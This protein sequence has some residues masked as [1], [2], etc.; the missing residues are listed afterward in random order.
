[1][2]EQPA[3][4]GMIL[5]CLSHANHTN[6]ICKGLSDGPLCSTQMKLVLVAAEKT[7]MALSLASRLSADFA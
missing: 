3:P 5:H 7:T 4:T 2:T 1:M 6:G